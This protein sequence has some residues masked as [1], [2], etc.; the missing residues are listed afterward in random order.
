MFP[1]GWT[2]QHHGTVDSTNDLAKD[3]ATQGYAEG[4]VVWADAQA[5][6]RGRSGRGW[7]SPIGNLYCS[8]VIR[9]GSDLASAGNLSF[10]VA[11]ALRAA[12]AKCC[13]C[14]QPQLKWPNDILVNGQKICGILLESGSDGELFVV[15]GTGINIAAV[16]P[17][18]ALPATSLEKE[19]CVVS[20][21]TLLS[22]YL[23]ALSTRLETWRTLGFAR[24]RAEWLEHCIGLGQP[25]VVRT[26]VS[27]SKGIFEGLAP[28]GALIFRKETGELSTVRAADVFFTDTAIRGEVH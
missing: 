22:A 1:E 12:I 5:A 24:I 10:I 15:A 6:G 26:E 2:V 19:G 28:D 14:T 25:I 7:S 20:P 23:T 11:V 8:A 17:G 9:P 21:E 18:L 4:T 13:P 3:L 27:Q 16:P